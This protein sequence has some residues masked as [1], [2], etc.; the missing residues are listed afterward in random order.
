[1]DCCPTTR[2]CKCAVRGGRAFV[3]VNVATLQLRYGNC[4]CVCSLLRC[5]SRGKQVCKNNPR[6]C[7]GLVV[8]AVSFCIR[9]G[10]R[11]SSS[12]DSSCPERSELT[13]KAHKAKPASCLEL[14][15]SAVKVPASPGSG[16][17]FKCNA[18]SSG[19]LKE[20]HSLGSP[21]APSR[22]KFTQPA[23]LPAL[24]WA[25][26]LGLALRAAGCALGW[27]ENLECF[28]QLPNIGYWF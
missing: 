3:E 1:M 8:C 14:P 19:V 12:K 17:W 16:F 4:P 23:C 13:G 22:S 9:G 7:V 28:N 5:N 25:V 24:F 6:F 18:V 2:K 10:E 20:S 27:E 11:D 15:T 26:A 21:A